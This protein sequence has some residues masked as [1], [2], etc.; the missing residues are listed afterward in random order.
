MPLYLLDT[1][2]LSLIQRNVDKVVLRFLTTPPTEVGATIISYEEQVRGRLAR[3]NQARTPASQ[4]EAY[5]QLRQTQ[6]FYCRLR[7]VDFDVPAITI[8]EALRSKHRRADTMDLRIAATALSH[9]AILVT[10][11]TQDFAPIENLPLENWA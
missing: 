11:N 10:R 7:L 3:L 6:N 8:Y 1:D 9:N 4:Q 5:A 2:H